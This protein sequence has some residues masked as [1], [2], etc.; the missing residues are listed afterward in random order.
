MK[1]KRSKKAGKTFFFRFIILY[2]LFAAILLTSYVPVA[3]FVEA[4]VRN[5]ILERYEHS[6][7]N[8]TASFDAAIQALINTVTVTYDDPKFRLFRM[9]ADPGEMYSKRIDFD[10]CKKLLNGLISSNNL[11]SDA[12]I[13]F[14]DDL[15]L[16]RQRSFFY[17]ENYS[18]YPDFF[19]C[20]SLNF[21]EWKASLKNA[22]TYLPEATFFSQD[23]GTY[24]AIVFSLPWSKNGSFTDTL[25]YATLP[26]SR[27]KSLFLES[28]ILKDGYLQI[29]IG[30]TVLFETG[31]PQPE[32]YNMLYAKTDKSQLNINLG[33]PHRIFDADIRS[34][35]QITVLFALALIIATLVLTLFFSYRSARP[36]QDIIQVINRTLH[37]RKTYE[38]IPDDPRKQARLLREYRMIGLSLAQ[39][40]EKINEYTG[41]IERQ[42]SALQKQLMNMA[43]LSGLYRE[44]QISLFL[45]A[46]PHFPASYRLS[47]IYYKPASFETPD[48]AILDQF[49]ITSVLQEFFPDIYIQGLDGA[50]VMLLLPAAGSNSEAER[51]KL[52]IV[53]Q[54]LTDDFNIPF[55]FTLSSVFTR[56]QDLP[57]AYQ[58]AQYG[59]IRSH[60]NSGTASK[61]FSS[62]IQ[63]Q[64]L[65]L[66][67]DMLQIIYSALC[68]GNLRIATSVLEEC[69][70]MLP[71]DNNYLISKHTHT[72][73]ASLILQI[74]LEQFESTFDVIIPAFDHVR[75]RED[76]LR[77]FSD[78][79]AKICDHVLNT[80]E[81]DTDPLANKVLGYVSEQLSN[82]DLCITMVSDHFG[83]SAPTLQKLIKSQTGQTFSAYVEENRLQHAYLKLVEGKES[84]QSIATGCGFSSSNSFY[85]AFMRRYNTPPSAIMPD[86]KHASTGNI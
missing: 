9:H 35:H 14:S 50:Y 38:S 83:I 19:K 1:I 26:T 24:S 39:I 77:E 51:D 55:S 72:M 47:L 58:Q 52:N 12:A 84:V 70:D 79:F 59:S 48:S 71:Q 36:M 16:T 74:K 67:I 23:Y 13:I 34:L 15:I 22:K 10:Q 6:L 73:L 86:K 44:D 8:S 81:D 11:I 69:V 37:I 32:L 41:I 66:R 33:I 28:D 56:A 49:R 45:A 25:F 60:S 68:N 17:P 80:T 82:P 53:T 27:I 30:N 40:D 85:K 7:Y 18:Y 78:C 54:R 4:R 65:P 57:R 2:I 31:N 62:D 75:K 5:N 29:S 21:A 3:R 42:N 63:K 46:F 20:G 76:F 43:V 64:Q 61:A